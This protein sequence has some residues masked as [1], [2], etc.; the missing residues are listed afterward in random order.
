MSSKTKNKPSSKPSSKKELTIQNTRTQK[1]SQPLNT[2]I[3][4]NQKKSQQLNTQIDDNQK[5][6]NIDS[7][8]TNLLQSNTK[9]ENEIV[10]ANENIKKLNNKKQEYEKSIKSFDDKI[11]DLDENIKSSNNEVIL[12]TTAFNKFVKEE[13]FENITKILETKL[14]SNKIFTISNNENVG[15]IYG[16]FLAINSYISRHDREISLTKNLSDIKRDINIE[17]G[18]KYNSI[19]KDSLQNLKTALEKYYSVIEKIIK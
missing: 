12:K 2:Q 19:S 7:D 4:D 9:I 15:V 10:E 5:I 11:I 1:K 16:N 14:T 17:I 8:I 18:R 6:N 13:N 3:D